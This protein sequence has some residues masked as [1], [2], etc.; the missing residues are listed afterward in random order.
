MPSSLKGVICMINTLPIDDVRWESERA[1]E[2]GKKVKNVSERVFH[3]IMNGCAV[4]IV[5]C[6]DSMTQTNNEQVE[7]MLQI[8]DKNNKIR[9][10]AHK[11]NNNNRIKRKKNSMEKKTKIRK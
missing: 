9:E 5:K 7:Q 2:R 1:N 8:H 6:L 10:A 4:S 3:S 11:N